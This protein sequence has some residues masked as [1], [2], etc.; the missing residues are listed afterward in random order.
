MNTK[1]IINRTLI[2]HAIACS[3]LVKQS[4]KMHL[5]NLGLT[6][7]TAAALNANNAP[8]ASKLITVHTAIYHTNTHINGTNK[9]Y[10]VANLVTAIAAPIHYVIVCEKKKEVV[11]NVKALLR[12][13][14][15]KVIV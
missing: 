1:H 4:K 15:M 7:G 14:K 13:I 6:V 2:T 10:A 5:M 8:L 3:I 12:R 11:S 9:Q